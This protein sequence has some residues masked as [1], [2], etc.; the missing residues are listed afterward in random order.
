[1]GEGL[2]L[3][4]LGGA[5]SCE[6]DRLNSGGLI[7]MQLTSRDRHI[8]FANYRSMVAY[9]YYKYY[10]NSKLIRK[11]SFLLYYKSKHLVIQNTMLEY[12][13]KS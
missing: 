6:N 10:L 1:M 9:K 2:R 8:G 5:P 3:Q 12:Q 13:N 11:I 4:G 7:R